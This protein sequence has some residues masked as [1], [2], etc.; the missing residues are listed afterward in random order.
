MRC[1][2]AQLATVSRA[3]TLTRC[4]LMISNFRC[5]P[6]TCRSL[7]A[8][9]FLR[10]KNNLRPPPLIPTATIIFVHGHALCVVLAYKNAIAAQM[11][12]ADATR[13]TLSSP[14]LI[15]GIPEF[16]C[17]SL[18]M[19]ARPPARPPA[20]VDSIIINN[21]FIIIHYCCCSAELLLLFHRRTII[22]L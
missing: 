15:P 22:K 4:C 3:Q 1:G 17:L 5:C 16:G 20:C 2:P 10:P 11:L 21:I 19:P 8:S 13:P 18:P 14:C 6:S 7:A 9:R 12:L